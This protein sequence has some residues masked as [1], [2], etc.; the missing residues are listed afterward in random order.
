MYKDMDKANL[1]REL[2]EILTP[3]APRDASSHGG[4]IDWEYKYNKE[5]LNYLIERIVKLFN[6]FVKRETPEV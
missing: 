4:V 2:T 1:R 6:E 3:P 5:G